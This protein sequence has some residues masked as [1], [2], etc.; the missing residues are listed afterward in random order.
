M[1]LAIH[2]IHTRSTGTAHVCR[3]V[4]THAMEETSRRNR[5]C[6]KYLL[7]PR[8]R[9]IR[10]RGRSDPQTC[11]RLCNILQSIAAQLKE[12]G[13]GPE[14]VSSIVQRMIPLELT[15]QIQPTAI[16]LLAPEKG[17]KGLERKSMCSCV[18]I[19]P[20]SNSKRAA[21]AASA[22]RPHS[23]PQIGRFTST[24]A[25]TNVGRCAFEQMTLTPAE[26]VFFHYSK[27]KFR[28]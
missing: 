17:T 14:K 16:H 21:T 25:R 23:N 6:Q 8:N 2:G 24:H 13:Q 26:T 5:K 22:A 20:K 10:Q 4:E 27:Y 3:R 15:K 9:L 18:V 7:L 19:S 28:P 1:Q 12:A 11:F